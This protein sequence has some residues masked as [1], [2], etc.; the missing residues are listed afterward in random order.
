MD[1]LLAADAILL[2]L[3][4]LFPNDAKEDAPT[5]E[6]VR[7]EAANALLLFRVENVL[8]PVDETPLRMLPLNAEAPLEEFAATAAAR[9]ARDA[10]FFVQ[11]FVVVVGAILYLVC[12]T[13]I[14]YKK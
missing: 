11:L 6:A 1:D 7:D 4:P 10:I 9:H 14:I 8:P 3:F 2:P 5:T 12:V 13:P